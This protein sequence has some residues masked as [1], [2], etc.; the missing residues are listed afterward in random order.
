MAAGGR[1][2]TAGGAIAAVQTSHNVNVNSVKNQRYF[3]PHQIFYGK[4]N[5][6]NIENRSNTWHL[7]PKQELELV[8]TSNDAPTVPNLVF[9]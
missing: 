9:K 5:K 1:Y 3:E 8:T 6:L 4:I 7:L 2:S